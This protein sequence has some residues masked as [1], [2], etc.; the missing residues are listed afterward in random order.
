MSPPL[1]GPR[2]LEG[3]LDG[4]LETVRAEG[5]PPRPPAPPSISSGAHERDL[6][7]HGLPDPDICAGTGPTRTDQSLPGQP[8]LRRPGS[9]QQ[10]PDPGPL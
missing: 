7:P 4:G 10:L 3:A 9:R 8:E 2:F 1:S 6:L 5:L